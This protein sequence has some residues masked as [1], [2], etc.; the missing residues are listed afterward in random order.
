MSSL[1][2]PIYLAHKMQNLSS[3]YFQLSF[4]VTSMDLP[5]GLTLE[6]NEFLELLYKVVLSLQELEVSFFLKLHFPENINQIFCL[7]PL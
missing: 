3:V 2:F 1:T 5:I 4:H 7:G 6:G